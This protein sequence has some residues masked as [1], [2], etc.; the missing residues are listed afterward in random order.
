[1]F[2][3]HTGEWKVAILIVYVDNIIL[4]GNDNK[5]LERLKKV[6]AKEF[7]I[8]NLGNLKYFLGM[9]FTR[10]KKGI[11]VSQRKYVLDLLGVPFRYLRIL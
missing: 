11:F 9:E 7:E 4:T 1:M 3:R 5:E 8:K 6:L 10:S 2:Y